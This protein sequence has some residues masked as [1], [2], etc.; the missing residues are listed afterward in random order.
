MHEV[1]WRFFDRRR[2]IEVAI[3]LTGIGAS[4]C[5]LTLGSMLLFGA[6]VAPTVFQ[7]LS[8]ENAGVFLRR[9]FP[10]MYLFC[11]IT[12]GAAALLFTV[13]GTV[14][15]GI[16]CGIASALFLYSRGPLTE[17]INQARDQELAGDANARTRFERLH[18]LSVR[19]FG[20]QALTLLG[21][22]IYVHMI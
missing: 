22:G 2:E 16:C 10:R 21:I 20:L 15:L 5:W 1:V 12:T 6:V 17:R 3:L 13:A 7:T 14:T 18:K 9:V 19:L 8:P 4:I 11:A